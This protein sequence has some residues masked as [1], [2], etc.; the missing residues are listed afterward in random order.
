[1]RDITSRKQMEEALRRSEERFRLVAHATKD[2]LS[3]WD[4]RNGEIWRSDNFWEQFGYPPRKPEPDVEAWQEL[5]HPEDRDRVWRGLHTSFARHADFDE[6][7]YRFR[8]ADDSYA[9]ILERTYIVYADSGEPI[10]A[11]SAMTDLSDRRELEEQFRQAQKMEAVGRLAG[12]V[13]HDF[14]NHLM[15][16][17]SYAE[18]MRDQLGPKDSLRKSL[19]QVFKAAERA[20][21]LT[22]QLL[23]FSRKQVL[24]PS[25]IDLNSVIEDSLKMIQ[26]LIGEDIELD[27]SFDKSL[28]AVKADPGQIVQVLMNLC[29]NARDAMSSGG[30]LRIETANVSV[31]VEESRERQAL[32]PGDYVSL[33]VTDAGTGMTKDVQAHLFDPFFTTKGLGRGTGLG[34][35]TVYGIVKQSGG[36]IW[37]DSEV[38]RGSSFTIYFPAS[39]AALTATTTPEARKCEGEGET[40]LLVEDE[41]ALRESISEYLTLHGYKVLKARDGAE[42]L[43]I[44][45]QQTG[46]I[47]VLITDVI[48]P[49]LSGAEV[50]REV[51]KISPK[52]VTLYMSGY[53]D[54]ELIDYDSSSSTSGF[55]QKPFAL[56]ALLEKLAEMIARR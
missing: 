22:Q 41:A 23:A 34:L 4:I 50:A 9:V 33:V 27:V 29:V 8:R 10:R 1:M 37:V 21:A 44:A 31:D 54:R 25:I 30:K 45:K 39:E 56:S 20:A 43:D 17:T 32:V 11:L 14:N 46:S 47:Q 7:E 13:A 26:R 36:Y 52:V 51:A 18:M 3:D 6:V 28:W 15:V 35:S 48:I 24:S 5:V 16:I 55:L 40:V 12:G 2:A 19:A 42:A 38:G 49:K 53:T